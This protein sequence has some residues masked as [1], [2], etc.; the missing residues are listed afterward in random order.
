MADGV[1]DAPVDLGLEGRALWGRAWGHAITWLSPDSDR[2]AIE[3]AARL[4]DDLSSARRRY[5]A[6]TD[7]ADGRV[8]V[9]LSRQMS[10]SLSSLGFTPTARARLGVA[11]VKKASALESLLAKQ[12]GRRR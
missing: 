12:A 5:R 1:P 2:D 11:E 8:V 7:P 6:T 9:A 10:D 3:E 4:A